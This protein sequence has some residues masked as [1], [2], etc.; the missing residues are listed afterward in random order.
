MKEYKI[1]YSDLTIKIGDRVK[2]FSREGTVVGI[3]EEGRIY[4][5]IWIIAE[6]DVPESRW[7]GWE[8]NEDG[9]YK[10]DDK[11]ENLPIYEPD[12]FIK[13]WAWANIQVLDKEE[14]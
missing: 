14:K 12:R 8:K 7:I 1:P 3:I 5:R 9:T 10:V 13:M 2:Q 4:K 11:G 6:R